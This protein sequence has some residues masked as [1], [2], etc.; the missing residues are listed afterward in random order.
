MP[1]PFTRRMTVF[2]LVLFCAVILVLATAPTSPGAADAQ[3]LDLTEQA[4]RLH[5]AER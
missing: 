4:R 3:R 1:R 5:P 2:T